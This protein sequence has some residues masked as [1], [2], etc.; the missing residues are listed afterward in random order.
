MK[1]STEIAFIMTG[2]G[3]A[4][5]WAMLGRNRKRSSLIEAPIKGGANA[6]PKKENEEDAFQEA[7]EGID[8]Y[9]SFIKT[10]YPYYKRQPKNPFKVLGKANVNLNNAT[11]YKKLQ[12]NYETTQLT[13][14]NTS[15]IEREVRLWAGNKKPPISPALP[16]DIAD[17]IFRTIIASANGSTGIYPQGIVVNP[18]NGFTYIANQLS[19]NI[20][21]LNSDGIVISL[22]PITANGS[23][24]YGASPVD[25]T[26][27][28]QPS[29]PN[30]GKVYVANVIGDTVTVIN[31][32][33]EVT[34]T[35]PVGKRPIGITFNAFNSNV[36]V[37]NIGDDTVSVIDSITET[38]LTTIAVGK[39]PKSVAIRPDNGQVYV[40]NS[41][42][43]SISSI[44]AN[45]QVSATIEN[46]GNELTTAGY[47]PKNNQLYVV[48]SGESTVIPI[49]LDTNIP[50]T[51]IPVGAAPY[52]IL[53]NPNNG[54][55]YVGNRADN[56]YSIIDTDTVIDTLSLGTVGTSMGIDSTT[57]MIFSSDSTTGVVTLISYS[58]E[59]NVI[60]IN[61]GYYAKRED[62][63][64]NPAIVQHVKFILSGT[65]RFKVL[66]LEE[67]SVTGTTQVKPISF[68]SYHNPQNFGNV[69]EVFEMK[70]AIIDGKNGWVFKI[71]G[72]QTIT[73]LTYYKQFETENILEHAVLNQKNSKV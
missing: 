46:I 56:T 17:H 26:V 45:N 21:V 41:G 62:F 63:T 9:D 70:G 71:A 60:L 14:T 18:Y 50:S 66:K 47:N 54:L 8:P 32:Q 61:E 12:Q 39:A 22:I 36:Y 53:Y 37:T 6:I 44:D 52:R 55:L 33:L 49:D 73:I 24:P 31:Q 4:A 5:L 3:I 67:E 23:S 2:I 58:R 64:F 28:S 43:N 27:N 29:S 7:L 59:S 38:I 42:A 20:S 51:A 69:A 10:D 1:K 25:L 68:S 40:I 35:I 13:L 57:G 65:Q 34:T 48:S 72:K 19:H 11:F 16:G 30:F 15:D